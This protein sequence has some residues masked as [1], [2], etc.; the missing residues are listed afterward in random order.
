MTIT[1]G[2]SA[3]TEVSAEDTHLKMIHITDLHV[4]RQFNEAIW[5]DFSNVCVRLKPDLLIVSGDLVDNPFRWR[6]Q[7]ASE[8]LHQ[9]CGR[10][11]SDGGNRCRL[12]VVPGNHDTRVMGLLP[13]ARRRFLLVLNLVLLV[14]LT[15]LGYITGA[16]RIAEGSILALLC[17]DVILVS[18]FGRF[19]KYFGPDEAIAQRAVCS[20]GKISVEVYPFDS[21]SQ[22]LFLAGGEIP[23]AQFVS[24]R[25]NA[26]AN[27]L[28]KDE[29]LSRDEVTCPPYRIA[30]VHHHPLPIPY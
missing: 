18:L 10:V 30:V 19:E 28:S 5:Q 13:L 21:A 23:V 1:G 14:V 24:G 22:P 16:W 29:R 25:Q 7:R 9:L 11:A 2:P 8:K 3:V 26:E 20:I 12:I 4:G 15:A 17:V 27:P 6:L